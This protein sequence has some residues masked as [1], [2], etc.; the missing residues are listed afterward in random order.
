MAQAILGATINI[1]TLKGEV[2]LKVPA[3]SQPGDQLVM[4]GR[5]IRKLN[6]S[7]F[8]NQFVNLQVKI[9]RYERFDAAL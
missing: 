6:S 5:G 9:P 7:A 8:G 4:R 1:P 3:G 2:E